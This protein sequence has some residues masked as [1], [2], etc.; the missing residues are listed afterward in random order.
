[1]SVLKLIFPNFNQE[2]LIFTYIFLTIDYL[3]IT[4]SIRRADNR[5]FEEIIVMCVDND[6]NLMQEAE[7][8]E[9]ES[10]ENSEDES[11]S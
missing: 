3:K 2:T 9:D 8:A 6:F 7:D 1:M 10:T 11:T 4:F 5:H